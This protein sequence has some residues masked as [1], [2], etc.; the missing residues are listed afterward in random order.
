M[1]KKHIVFDARLYGPQHTGIGRYIQNLLKNF[2]K[3]SPSFRFTLLVDQKN[4]DFVKKDLKRD[5][6][7]IPVNIPHYS[8]KE[9]ILIPPLLAKLKPDL[10]H[11]PHFNRPLFWSGPSV[12][13]LHDLIKHQSKGSKT[14]TRSPAIYWLKFLAYKTLTRQ[15]I[16]KNHLIVPSFYWKDFLVKKFKKPHQE[17]TVTHEAVD[18]NFEKL[19]QKKSK[20]DQKY[21]I[22]KPYLVYT[23]NLYPH[24]N[25]DIVLKALK[26]IPS[27][28]LYICSKKNNFWEKTKE[29][30]ESMKLEKQVKLLDFP[31]DK[32]VVALYKDALALV[33]PSKIEGFGLTGLEA[34]NCSCPVI[35]SNSSCLPE[36]YGPGALYFDPDDQTTLQKH[37]NSLNTSSKERKQMIELGTKQTQKYSWKKTSQ[38]TLAV[39]KNLLF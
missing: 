36:V 25:I 32:T 6:N 11:F 14:T 26:N 38:K 33:H 28:Y 1:N 12:I 18:P 19:C 2:P 13:T 34:M 29:K 27:V 15:V 16:Q 24:K 4:H 30:V 8:I 7:L 20:L 35:S 22:K 39:Y 23:G 21:D 9:Q 3:D 17:I 31:S 10:V 5:F 37:I